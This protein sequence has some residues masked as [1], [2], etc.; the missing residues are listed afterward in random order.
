MG[1]GRHF[2]FFMHLNESEKKSLSSV[3][4]PKAEAEVQ[5]RERAEREALEAQNR[6]TSILESITDA[7]FA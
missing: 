4:M 7:F 6:V 1:R 5:A 3:A 2:L